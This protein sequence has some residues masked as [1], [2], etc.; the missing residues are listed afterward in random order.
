MIWRCVEYYVG[1]GSDAVNHV[2]TVFRVPQTRAGLSAPAY[3]AV[4]R[5][6]SQAECLGPLSL[7]ITAGPFHEGCQ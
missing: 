3:D 7:H 1:G 4:D 5:V 2:K 6:K